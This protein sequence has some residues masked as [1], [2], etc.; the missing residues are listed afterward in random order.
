MRAVQSMTGRGGWPMSVFL[1][2]DA[3]PFYAGTYWPR[4]PRPGMP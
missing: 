4:E 1:T 2:H 3:A